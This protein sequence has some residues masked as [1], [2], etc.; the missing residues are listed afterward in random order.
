[1]RWLTSGRDV[2]VRDFPLLPDAKAI[3]QTAGA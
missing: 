3:H 1:M 2:A